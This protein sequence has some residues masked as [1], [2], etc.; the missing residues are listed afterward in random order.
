MPQSEPWPKIYREAPE[1]FEAFSR[2]EDPEG[3]V[4]QRLWELAGFPGRRILEIG[5]GTGRYSQ[6]LA[7]GTAGYFALEPNPGMLGL[8]KRGPGE[9][10]HLVRARGQALP[11]RDQSVDLVV[12]SWV[13]A[14]LRPEVMTSVIKEAYR[15]L[16]PG[17]GR[18]IWLVENHWTGAFQ[19]LRERA[20]F[21]GEPGVKRLIE[22]HGF[23][24]RDVIETELRFP[25]GAEAEYVL[26]ALC[27][28]EVRKRLANEP[29]AA[30]GHHIVLLHHPPV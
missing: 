22:D 18:G 12:A 8:A 15:V 24:V 17:S 26:G 13:L 9:G 1:I 23:Q 7:P 4:V 6:A 14:Y 2:A 20:G 3:L 27:G 16:R 30:L 10:P 25:S 29:R 19:A 11:L 28:S 5:C 21:G